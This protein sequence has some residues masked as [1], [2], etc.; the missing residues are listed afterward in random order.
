MRC[1]GWYSGGVSPIFMEMILLHV[2]LGG[3]ISAFLSQN[4]TPAL[5]ERTKEKKRDFLTPPSLSLFSEYQL[6][7]NIGFLNMT[8]T[9]LLILTKEVWLLP[10]MYTFFI[11]HILWFSSS[12]GIWELHLY[13]SY[14]QKCLHT[15]GPWNHSMLQR[16]LLQSLR[17][18][19]SPP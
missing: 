18:S 5:W 9:Y 7:S 11:L 16:L 3:D 4:L 12:M 13:L 14:F 6:N 1:A 8:N 2:T 15:I 19:S 17:P 10:L